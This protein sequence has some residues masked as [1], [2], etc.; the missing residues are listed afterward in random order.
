MAALERK[1]EEVIAQVS[2]SN[3]FTQS[4]NAERE[5]ANIANANVTTSQHGNASR[6]DRTHS[7]GVLNNIEGVHGLPTP[8]SL[9]RDGCA[10]HASDTPGS[11]GEFS[12]SATSVFSQFLSDG[13]TPEALI[14]QGHLSI[15]DV[16][17]YIENFREMCLY[18]PFVLIPP[19]TS[20]YALL[21]DRPLLLH[22][23]LAVATSSEVHLQKVL[24]KSFKEI[25]LNRLV[26]EAE[27]TIDLLQSILI[28]IAW[29]HFFH[30]PKR[31]QS[32]QLLQMAIG[33][34]IELGLNLTPSSAMQKIGLHLGHY[35]PSGDDE[36]DKFWSTEAKR[37]YLGCYHVST[38]NNWI[39]AKPNTLEYSN[40]ILECARS[41]SE[42][43]EFATDELVLPLI[44]LQQIGD[45][46]HKVLQI[47]RNESYCQRPLDR[48]GTHIRSFHKRIQ[49]LRD[50]LTPV[51]ANSTVVQLAI[52]FAAVHTHEQD[53][54]SPFIPISKMMAT[55]APLDPMTSYMDCPSRIDVLL[56]CLQAAMEYLDLFLTIPLCSY[57][58]LCTSQW[59]GLIYSI[60]IMYRLSIGTP[61]VPLWD[62]QVARDTAKLETYL[63]MLCDKMQQATQE[64][65]RAT[66]ETNKRDLYSVMG[67]VF[68]NVRNTYERLRRLPQAQ[69]STDDAPVHATSFPDKEFIAAEQ[70]PQPRPGPIFVREQTKPGYQNR[71]PAMQFWSTSESAGNGSSD[72]VSDDPLSNVDVFNDDGF[73]NQTFAMEQTQWNMD[74]GTADF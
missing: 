38:M 37:A 31:N 44:Q 3:R 13:A 23:V 60:V 65:L 2:Q 64:R 30:V 18:F 59:S 24:E 62:V 33:L 46:Y 17:H 57:P 4:D 69:S 42:A 58:L 51:A 22:A 39:W 16:E 49:D 27:K 11:L 66:L 43:P 53:L 73:W 26:L 52:H 7:K 25:M 9:T 48:I 20:V 10:G 67:L 14:S 40:Y 21:K 45:E 12:N 15:Q 55:A 19:C 28:C 5:E 32:Y 41:I 54:L 63:A 71:C 56:H 70:L 72:F 50:N 68:Q 1:L 29:G 36:R 8:I 47:G 61:R 74:F 35:Q 34:C 6:I